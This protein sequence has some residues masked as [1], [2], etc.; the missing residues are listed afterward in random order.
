MDAILY[1][2]L[3][4][5]VA[6][7]PALVFTLTP[8]TTIGVPVGIALS[9]VG[10]AYAVVSSMRGRMPYVQRSGPALLRRGGL[11][12]ARKDLPP[13]K[14]QRNALA[15][16]LSA[17]VECRA[18]PEAPPTRATAIARILSRMLTG[19]QVSDL[20]ELPPDLTAALT[21]LERLLTSDPGEAGRLAQFF[22]RPD[23]VLGLRDET[24]RIARVRER[25]DRAF[26][27]FEATRVMQAAYPAPRDLRQA[28]E[29]LGTPDTDLW[30]RIVME[31]DPSDPAQ[32]DAA[33]WCVTQ[34][35]CDRASVAAYFARLPDGAQLQNAALD[36]DEA[37]L[38]RIKYLI[39]RC[40]AS[41][42]TVQEIAF[43]PPPDAAN[44]LSQELDALAALTEEARWPDPQ[45]VLRPMEGR[46]PRPRRTWD[47][48]AGRLTA[49][50]HRSDY[51]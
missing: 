31:H 47:L 13:I 36:G 15:D 20:N 29:S 28:L 41:Y 24:D 43:T 6:I 48:T 49:P 42:Y 34:A 17:A 11:R 25:Y 9:A 16:A 45:C 12:R 39:S 14:D 30:H 50:P 46:A 2:L 44:R 51:L 38:Q 35:N 7:G 5:G 19:W 26:A 10:S 22:Q 4:T 37:F 32:R 23:L 27:A 18:E 1:R 21:L 40:N 8:A 33:L 3:L